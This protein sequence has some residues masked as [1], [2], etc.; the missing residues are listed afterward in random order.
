L[1]SDAPL[2][3]IKP[4]IYIAYALIQAVF[5]QTHRGI[6]IGLLVIN[7]ATIFLLFFLA[8]RLFDPLTAVAAAAAFAILS[9][10][11]HVLGFSANREHFVILP[12]LGG[13][14]LVLRAINSQRWLSLL[15]GALLLGISFTMKPNGLFF[16][17]FAG[18]Y[19][20]LCEIRRRPFSLNVFLSRGIAFTLGVI[21]P[22]ALLCLVLWRLGLFRTYWFWRFEYTKEYASALSL[23]QGLSFLKIQ[24]PNIVRSALCIWVLAGCGLTG[25][26]WDERARQRGLFVAGFVLFSFLAV[27]PGFYFREHYFILFLPAVALLTGVGAGCIHNLF[28]RVCKPSTAKVALVVSLL[29]VLYHAVYQQRNYFFVMSSTKVS[30]TIYGGNPFIESLEIARF[31]KENSTAGDHIAVL[32]S[33]PQIYFYSGRY[34]ATG[35]MYT[36]PLMGE[37][38]FALELQKQMIRE[39]ELAKPKFLVLVNIHTS[40]LVQPNSE[41]LI[42][43][44]LQ[45]YQEKYYRQVGVIDIMPQ[46][47]T[48][49]RW[50]DRAIEYTPQS[51]CWLAVFQRNSY[52]R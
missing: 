15:A 37:Y 18:L 22:L 16:I 14:L 21:L 48:V 44:W 45:E 31:I 4:G 13:I 33:E 39:I 28:A 52:D 3:N 30:R 42:F 27:C 2:Y 40:W 10:G 5:G 8:K 51:N 36:Y 47:Q 12:A 49:Y 9:I 43:E 24:I 50:Y 41:K 25:L 6:H 26:L 19:L 35:H 7:A 17:A 34:A 32:G 1:P 29:V 38:D 11:Q 23:R 20:L 46:D